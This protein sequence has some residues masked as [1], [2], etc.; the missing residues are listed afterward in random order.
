MI[1]SAIG[2][3]PVIFLNWIYANITLQKSK[4]KCYDYD[5]RLATYSM[6][7]CTNSPKFCSVTVRDSPICLVMNLEQ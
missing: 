1:Y 2:G 5:T 6:N 4:P 3:R 7:P